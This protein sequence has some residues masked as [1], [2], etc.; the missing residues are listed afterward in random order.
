MAQSKEQ[1]LWQACTDGDLELVKE[2]AKDDSV[3]VNWVGEDRRDTPLHRAS[4]FGH[5]EIAKLLLARSEIEVNKGNFGDASPFLVACHYGH[6]EVVS[7]LLADPRVDPNKVWENEATPSMQAC[8]EGHKEVLLLLLADPRIDPNKSATDQS[9]PVWYASQNG[10]LAV[11]QHLLASG[12]EIDTQIRSNFNDST[13]AEQGRSIGKRTT[14]PA[15]ETEDDFQ[16]RKTN[17][18]LCADLIDE[19]ERDPVG[20]LHRLRRQSGLRE[21]FI[22][23]LFA[24]VIFH[25]DNY[26]TVN[27]RTTDSSRNF[28]RI[29]T[30]LPLELKMVLG[31]RAFGSPKDIVLSRD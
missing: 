21:Y 23:H 24:L 12:R 29:A 19:Y 9:T 10:H 15:D 14:K 27:E 26:L 11:V 2:L 17:G 5:L 1:I 6:K 16:R 18:P 8:Q 13:A 7:L 4:R 20:V 25:S 28:F 3:D 22:G 31:N 30:R